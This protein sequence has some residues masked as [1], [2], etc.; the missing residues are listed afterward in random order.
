[1]SNTQQCVFPVSTIELAGTTEQV[2]VGGRDKFNS[3]QDAFK[4]VR[5][6]GVIGWG[7][8]GPAQAQNL[9][10]SLEAADMSTVVKVGLREGSKSIDKATEA[11]LPVGEMYQVINESDLVLLLTSD[12]SQADNFKQILAAMKPGATLGL[13]HGFLLGHMKNV[14]AKFRDDINVIGVCPKGM[15]PSVR[16]LYEQGKDINGAGINCS[17][18]VERNVTGNA[19]NIALGWAVAI[20]APYVFPTTLE[21]EYKSDIFGERA[22]L[23]GGVWGMLEALYTHFAGKTNDPSAAFEF[24][25]LSLTGPISKAI[26]SGGLH[27]V[28]Y[29]MDH[30]EHEAFFCAMNATYGP[31]KALI[32]EIYAE[33]ASGREIASVVDATKRLS[34]YPFSKVEGSPMWRVG[35]EV[36]EKKRIADI[37]PLTAG[38]Y[39]GIM[40]AQVDTLRENGHSWSEVCNESII[41]AVD[42][43]NP[44]MAARGIDYMV[45]NCSTT[46]RLGGRKWGPR[47][48]QMVT[49]DVL[50]NIGIG[51]NSHKA[52]VSHPVHGAL[53]TCMEMRPPVDI[54]VT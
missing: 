30:G 32:A 17:Y 21:M 44:Y 39:L 51:F 35:K 24:S 2:V 28:L 9:R 22:V 49:G 14:K 38:I 53:A 3:L 5:H 20:G 11:G 41:E 52:F 23:L 40:L 19:H 48:A 8:Q 27:E 6:I 1:M 33:V 47:F 16:R 36:R 31:A 10:D 46:A 13:S 7:S 18:A 26:S 42:S 4:G 54:A 43:L 25:A 45:D 29:Q 15:G 34:Q 12:G 50:P 37:N